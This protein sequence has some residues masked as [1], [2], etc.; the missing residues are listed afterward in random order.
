MSLKFPMLKDDPVLPEGAQ[1]QLRA[2]GATLTATPPSATPAGSSGSPPSRP[3]GKPP[4]PSSSASPEPRT[5]GLAA[6]PTHGDAPQL[7]PGWQ[8][9]VPS[10]RPQLEHQRGE[11]QQQ[12]QQQ[13]QAA[14]AADTT[15]VARKRPR[16]PAR[17]ASTSGIELLPPMPAAPPPPPPG[18]SPGLPPRKRRKMVR[19]LRA[20][21]CARRA[22]AGRAPLP[23]QP[24]RQAGKLPRVC[25]PT[26]PSRVRAFARA[27]AEDAP[28]L[29]SHRPVARRPEAA[30]RRS[31]DLRCAAAA[32]P[33]P[34]GGGSPPRGEG[35]PRG[36]GR[37]SAQHKRTRHPPPGRGGW[38]G[39][40]AS[41]CAGVAPD[42]C[43]RG[44]RRV[45]RGH[46]QRPKCP[47]A[48]RHPC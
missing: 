44:T 47:G 6:P 17:T 37:T 23:L 14:G 12:Q 28:P 3:Q 43:F 2:R 34:R 4:G 36:Q 35:A 1:L 9:Q 31:R 16:K 29:C 22:G 20:S 30:T 21:E 46:P 41:G 10:G 8:V 48:L 42:S 5:A 19:G 7:L 33:S 25:G 27:L 39:L 15:P 38:R 24:P 45:R 40:V 18:P 26:W 13:Q 32:R 11:Q